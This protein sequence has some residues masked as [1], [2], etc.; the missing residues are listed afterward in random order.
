[1]KK[2]LEPNKPTHTIEKKFTSNGYQC[3]IL[4]MPPLL[5][6]RCGYVGVPTTH[7]LYG[8]R[9]G[10]NN[11]LLEKIFQSTNMG[12]QSIGKRGII[13]LFCGVCDE[14]AGMAPDIFFDVHGSLTFS[15]KSDTDYP[16]PVKE[17][18]WWYGYDC[19]HHGD[20]E[21]GGQSL[22]YCIKECKNLAKQLKEVEEFYNNAIEL[23]YQAIQSKNAKKKS[24]E[25]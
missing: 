15:E 17:E 3:A 1:M 18:L 23:E 19:G 21:D 25:V 13:P 4:R 11:I 24:K 8:V 2:Q 6:H 22:E 20:N 7:P 16:I 14:K 5:Y 10:T 12:E 9:Y